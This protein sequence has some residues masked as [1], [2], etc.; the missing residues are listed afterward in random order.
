ML[1]LQ[2]I[3]LK[4]LDVLAESGPY[5]L[6]GFAIAGVLHVLLPESVFSRVFGR[7]GIK[8]LLR[9]IGLGSL[10]PIC[11]CGVV[12]IGIG[13][14]RGGA[15]TGTVLA[16]MTA[17]PTLSPASVLLSL[18]L[19]G[20]PLT[21][22]QVIMVA[23]G[24]FALG[25]LGNR[26]FVGLVKPKAEPAPASKQPESELVTLEPMACC[27]HHEPAPVSLEPVSPKTETPLDS[28]CETHS[29][30]GSPV[31]KSSNKTYEM[32][33][34]TFADFGPSV[35]LDM[36]V[37]LVFAATVLTLVPSDTIVL[38]T[39]SKTIWSLL[40]VV[41]VALPVYTCSMA[42]LPV[43]F[44]FL[45][46]GMSPG[47]AIAFIIAGPATNFGEMNAIRAQI[48]WRQ[49]LYYF[50][51]LVTVAVASGFLLDN[52]IQP[53]LPTGIENAQ[54]M[55]NHGVGY[56]WPQWVSIAVMAGMMLL[57]ASR[58]I[59]QFLPTSRPAADKDCCSSD[60]STQPRETVMLEK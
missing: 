13:A 41:V 45:A 49:S 53:P 2:A 26:L 5:I 36:L 54:H 31:Q 58:R 4:L 43:V 33:R 51:S 12:P 22:W 25:L 18:K 32:F 15:A 34:W 1:I 24:A 47:A 55:H 7:K 23:V 29:G 52:V 21:V 16:F 3:A 46:A 30:G 35:S 42:A 60:H 14:Y 50:V 56:G 27:A 37:G 40:L 9:A 48:G 59:R 28:C 20:M 19:L 38:L 6:L 44:S 57:E 17:A 10:I 8:P 11:S 39:G